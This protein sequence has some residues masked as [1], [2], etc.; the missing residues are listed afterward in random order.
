MAAFEKVLSGMPALDQAVDYIRMGDNVVWRVSSL[1]EFRCFAVPFVEQAKKDGRNIFW[2]T[3]GRILISFAPAVFWKMALIMLSRG[4]MNPSSAPIG[5]PRKN[6]WKN[7]KTRFESY[8]PVLP[9]SQ[10][11]IIAK[12]GAWING[13][14]RWRCWSCVFPAPLMAPIICPVQ[15]V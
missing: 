15:P 13:M 1:E 14:N 2:N 6:G 4:N 12:G 9:D 7:L 11:W 5:E 8:M 3:T 10:H